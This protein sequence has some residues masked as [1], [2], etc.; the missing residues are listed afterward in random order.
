[1]TTEQRPSQPALVTVAGV[2]LI[3]DGI[4]AL[5]FAGMFTWLSLVPPVAAIEGRA[6][7][8][9]TQLGPAI[10]FLVVG[11]AAC[12]A[13]YRAVRGS[14]SGRLVGIA[15]AAVGVGFFVWWL[16]A[17][18]PK[19]IA[20]FAVLFGLLV[21]EAVVAVTLVRWPSASSS[22]TLAGR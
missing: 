9:Q 20:G 14:R 7:A 11:V 1:M 22:V 16:V 21:T 10:A 6:P 4:V 3:L 15:V 18:P 8:T 12:W 17:S 13:G 5:L 2:V 19:G